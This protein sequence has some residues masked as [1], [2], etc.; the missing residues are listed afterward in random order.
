MHHSVHFHPVHLS[1][2]IKL[3]ITMLSNET[4]AHLYPLVEAESVLPDYPEYSALY[5]S[6]TLIAAK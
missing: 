5:V 3:S 4:A 2:H 1:A 6:N